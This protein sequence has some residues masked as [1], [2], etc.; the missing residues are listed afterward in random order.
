VTS[1]CLCFRY[2]Q[3]DRRR[4]LVSSLEASG[5]TLLDRGTVLIADVQE[6]CLAV[7]PTDGDPDP[8]ACYR[9]TR[10]GYDSCGTA[11]YVPAD[12][13][14][15]YGDPTDEPWFYPA[16]LTPLQASAVFRL[17]TVCLVL[18]L[19]MIYFASGY[20]LRIYSN[21]FVCNCLFIFRFN[22][23]FTVVILMYNSDY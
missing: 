20:I 22:V 2:S 17:L 14:K 19:S 9:R 10:L 8:I 16:S 6:P 11:F 4:Q 18:T 5:R 21:F 7:P 15:G 23:S 12:A 3:T 1:G 13:L